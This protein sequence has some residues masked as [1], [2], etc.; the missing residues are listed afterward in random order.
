M[1]KIFMEPEEYEAYLKKQEEQKAKLQ[2]YY[3]SL[4]EGD[5]TDVE[6]PT[7]YELNQQIIAQMPAL[8][9]DGVRECSGKILKYLEEH[10][11]SYYMLLCKELSY[12][13][14]FHITSAK[15]APNGNVII[16][17]GALHDLTEEIIDIIS[18][19]GDVRVIETDN[20]DAIAI[21]SSFQSEET[22]AIHCFYLFPYGRGV[23]EV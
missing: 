17:R 5:Q 12:Y 9:A 23:V 4:K 14:I 22:G 15:T 18:S 21:W 2:E 3:D 10:V 19:L 20:N 7:L 13:T 6:G 8:D 11:N 16:S 1:K